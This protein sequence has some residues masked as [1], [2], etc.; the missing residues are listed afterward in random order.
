MLDPTTMRHPAARH[1][2]GDLDRDDIEVILELFTSEQLF[3]VRPLARMRSGYA[4]QHH[5]INEDHALSN[6][7]FL[8]ELK[9][10]LR[11]GRP[12]GIAA[13]A[14]KRNESLPL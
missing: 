3:Q 14:H 10:G 5:G 8:E 1:A 9:L 13:L 12:F 2:V 7:V 4:R 11:T 6:T